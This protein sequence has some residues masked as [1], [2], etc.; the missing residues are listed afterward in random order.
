[1]VSPS[2]TSDNSH[3]TSDIALVSQRSSEGQFVNA[4]SV[5][6]TSRQANNGISYRTETITNAEGVTITTTVPC[7]NAQQTN[8]SGAKNPETIT[9]DTKNPETITGDTKNPDATVYPSQAGTRSHSENP[10]AKASPVSAQESEQRTAS[11]QVVT[12]PVQVQSPGIHGSSPVLT[13]V[14]TIASGRIASEAIE[15]YTRVI[16]G[17][18]QSQGAVPSAV[19]FLPN[20][21]N[22]ASRGAVGLLAVFFSVLC[23]WF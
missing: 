21:D 22:G 18:F 4:T 8:I 19:A 6:A 7:E 1:M 3:Y 14:V 9:G 5:M 10:G 17:S 13:S 2:Y 16:T 15:Q 11:E 23:L 20:S 12:S